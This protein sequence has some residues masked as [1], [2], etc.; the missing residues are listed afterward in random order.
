M[1]DARRRFAIIRGGWLWYNGRAEG[2][3]VELA[4]EAGMQYGFKQRKRAPM[5]AIVV[6]AVI[7]TGAGA[8]ILALAHFIFR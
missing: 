4:E 6:L 7:L 1:I 3:S 5:I 8:V 2:V